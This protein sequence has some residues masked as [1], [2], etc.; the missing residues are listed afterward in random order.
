MDLW[1][2]M[3]SY[4]G[5]MIEGAPGYKGLVLD[6]ETMRIC[7]NL[8]GRTELAEHNVVHVEN[9]EKPDGRAHNELKVRRLACA[10]LRV[11]PITPRREWTVHICYIAAAAMTHSALLA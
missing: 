9:L 6:K 5:S 7:A 10:T 2:I 11:H 3:R 4:V 8:Y 1:K